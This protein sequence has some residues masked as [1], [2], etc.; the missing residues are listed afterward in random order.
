[1]DKETLLNSM[2]LPNMK[3]LAEKCAEAGIAFMAAVD[4]PTN[5]TTHWSSAAQNDMRFGGA[6]LL[7]GGEFVQEEEDNGEE[8]VHV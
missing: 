6:I 2:I 7:L 4:T 1:M 8:E 3:V 5:F